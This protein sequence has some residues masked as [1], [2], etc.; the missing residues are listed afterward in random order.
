LK[1]PCP[2]T[3][4]ERGFRPDFGPPRGFSGRGRERGRMIAA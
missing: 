2:S 4:I 3:W 1:S